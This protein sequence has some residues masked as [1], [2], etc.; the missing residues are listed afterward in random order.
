MDAFEFLARFNELAGEGAPIVLFS[1]HRIAEHFQI[2][3]Y[4]SRRIVGDLRSANLIRRAGNQY[5]FN[6][7]G[8]EV[9][10]AMTNARSEVY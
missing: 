1:A 6:R 4:M 8:L 2:T 9:V 10:R 5:V 7:H 3:P